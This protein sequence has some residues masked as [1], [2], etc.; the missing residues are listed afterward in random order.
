MTTSNKPHPKRKAEDQDLAEQIIK[1]LRRNGYLPGE[2]GIDVAAQ[3]NL[4]YEYLARRY[5]FGY[6]LLSTNCRI[7]KDGSAEVI[8]DVIIE[9]HT[10][11]KE[12]DTF[13]TIPEE[14]PDKPP[15]EIG[16]GTIRSMDP[17]YD[18]KINTLEKHSQRIYARIEID[19]PLEPEKQL[20][21]QIQDLTL[22]GLYSIGQ[23]AEEIA[24]RKNTSD[25]WAWHITRPTK[26]LILRVEFPFGWLPEE[27]KLVTRYPMQPGLPNEYLLPLEQ[28]DPNRTTVNVDKTGDVLTAEIDFPLFNLIYMLIWTPK[29]RE[30]SRRR[31]PSRPG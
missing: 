29:V 4:M 5:G 31:S 19:P 28:T 27:Y 10:Q 1:V 30:A 20:N 18:L 9:A 13:I 26:K 17:E 21:Y 7:Q 3:D 25:Y 6:R 12:V 23:S 2:R 22:T 8:R 24:G 15:R 11:V 16:E 14:Y